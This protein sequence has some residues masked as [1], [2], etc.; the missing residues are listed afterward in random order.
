M[1]VDSLKNSLGDIEIRKQL[2]N[3]GKNDAISFLSKLENGV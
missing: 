2:F 3:D 1:S